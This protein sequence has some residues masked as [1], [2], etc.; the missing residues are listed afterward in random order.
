MGPIIFSKWREILFWCTSASLK[1]E[2][3]VQV[4]ISL[5]FE[6]RYFIVFS[7]RL[8]RTSIINVNTWKGGRGM[9]MTELITWMDG[10]GMA[11]TEFDQLQ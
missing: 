1:L 11:M 6:V 10:R 3:F 4:R 5:Y 8:T 2:Q 7:L 9:A